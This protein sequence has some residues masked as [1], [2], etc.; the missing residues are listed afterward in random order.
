MK[1]FEEDRRFDYGPARIKFSQQLGPTPKV[2]AEFDVS[3]SI[4]K[5]KT[6]EFNIRFTTE[7]AGIFFDYA[8]T[9]PSA[10]ENFWM[11]NRD[12]FARPELLIDWFE[13]EGPIYESWP[14]QT[15]SRILFD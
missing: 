7:S 4:D 10:L 12:T 13:I 9:I 6:H 8:Y 15:H 14:P 11:Q 3:G 2:M 5:P 1:H